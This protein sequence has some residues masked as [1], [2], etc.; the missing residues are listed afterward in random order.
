MLYQDYYDY[1]ENIANQLIDISYFHEYD[2]WEFDTSKRTLP[3]EIDIS[4]F[5]FFLE[6][7]EAGLNGQYL[8]NMRHVKRCSFSILKKIVTVGKKNAPLAK[9]KPEVLS[10]SEELVLQVVSQMTADKRNPNPKSPNR[11][12]RGLELNT[13]EYFKVNG[14]FDNLYGWRVE[15]EL[16][17]QAKLLKKPALWKG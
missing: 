4:G 16:H 8:D 12:L 15:F 7:Y 6:S 14:N 11:W 5:I 13:F 9:Q 10:K 3:K 1:F 17:S 2:I